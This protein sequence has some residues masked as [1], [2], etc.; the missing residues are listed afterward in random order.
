MGE[1]ITVEVCCGSADDAARAFLAG[2]D[3]IELNCALD[4]GG[5]TPSLGLLESALDNAP[6]PVVCMV[7]PRAGGFCYSALEFDCMLR[8]ARALCA[9][10]AAGLAFGCLTQDGRI[11]RERC[12]RLIDAAGDAQTVFHRAFDVL[13]GE[14]EADV[15]TLVR[16]G[17]TRI[18]TSGRRPAAPDGAD[19][20][21][22]CALAAANRI[23]ILAGGG[24]RE[25]NAAALVTAT[26]V[27]Q[28]H[29]SCHTTVCDCSA[30]GSAVHFNAPATASETSVSVVDTARLSDFVEMLRKIEYPKDVKI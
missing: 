25:N 28:L 16:L 20:I 19:C 2:A 9:A 29:F 24:V 8:D 22:R 12:A 18:L 27:R 23:E 10:G 13:R 26:G 17:F 15:E 7:R 14:P 11:D 30:S 21:R 6:L 5:L 4:A 3:R 1:Y